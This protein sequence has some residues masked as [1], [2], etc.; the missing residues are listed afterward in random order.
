MEAPVRGVD[1]QPHPVPLAQGERLVDRVDG[2]ERRGPGGQH[3]GTDRIGAQQVLE[4]VQVDPPPG[5]GGHADPADTEQVAHPLVGVV[6]LLA[7]G[8]RGSGPEL[9]GDEERLQVGDRPARGQVS[10]ELHGVMEHGGDGGHGLPLQRRRGRPPVEGVI[11]GIDEH[12]HQIRG[13][14]GGV[15]RL[16]HLT[17][18][19]G[20]EEG[21]VVPQPAA[22]LLQDPR[23]PLRAHHH[24][25]VWCDARPAGL[26]T[27]HRLD[28][29]Q[30]GGVE[31]HRCKSTGGAGEARRAGRQVRHRPGGQP[32]PS[33]DPF[34]R[35]A[36]VRIAI[37]RSA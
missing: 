5:V 12:R 9:P 21:V 24:R 17:G 6:A 30:A 29:L 22:Q 36:I 18:V 3:H 23:R 35:C 34:W 19:A 32:S 8:D 31:V 20:V 7:E 28:R 26:P 10:Q 37:C 2:P 25:G 1:V 27:P 33:L 16:E 4:G 13:G 11:V 14:R 15:G